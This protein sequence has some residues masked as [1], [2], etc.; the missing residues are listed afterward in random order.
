[1]GPPYRRRLLCVVFFSALAS[2]GLYFSPQALIASV[3][4]VGAVLNPPP[5]AGG[6]V[7]GGIT[8]GDGAYGS[9]TV[10]AGTAVTTSNTTNMGNALAGIGVLSLTGFGSDWT[11]TGATSDL[12]VGD[13]GVGSVTVDSSA[14][15]VVADDVF[16]GNLSTSSGS[17]TV[18][19]LGS[20]LDPGDDVLIG[21]AGVGHVDVTNGGGVD[22]DAIIVGDGSSGR[23]FVTITGDQS[24][25]T[26]GVVFV[27]DVG[28][29]RVDIASGGRLTTSGQLNLGNFA[30]SVGIVDVSGIGSLV[31]FPSAII[32]G[33]GTG[34]LLIRGGARVTSSGAITVGNSATAV[35]NLTVDGAGSRLSVVGNL[36]T[37][38]G[39]A[40]ITLSNGGVLSTTTSSLIN[41]LAR[42][43]LAGGRWEST[44]LASDAIVVAGLLEG[45]GTIDAQGVTINVGPPRGRLYTSASDHMLITGLVDN[46]GLVDLAGGELEI[47]GALNNSGDIDARHGAT[48]RVGNTGFDN[49][50]GAQLAITSGVVDVFG[51]VDNNAGAE[52]AVVGGATGIFH[53]AVTNSGT[54]FVSASSEIVLLGSLSFVPGSTIGVDLA[55]ITAT[56]PPTDAFGLLDII[57]ST[58]LSG[59]LSV[60][61]ASGF[62]PTLGESYQILRASGGLAGTFAS[63]SLPPLGG[64]MALKVVYDPT[65]V[66]LKIIQ[67]VSP[68]F[69]MDGDIDGVDADLLVMEIVAMTNGSLFDLTGDGSVTAADLSQW[70]VDAGAANLPSGNPYLV[71]DANLNGSVDG[72]DFIMWNSNKFT[73]NPRWTQ[74][75]FNADGFVDG[76]DFNLWNE[77]KFQSSAIDQSAVPEP[78]GGLLGLAMGIAVAFRSNPTR[79]GLARRPATTMVRCRPWQD[80]SCARETGPTAR[81]SP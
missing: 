53:D 67:A 10:T 47:L 51:V 62:I 11:I 33:S 76:S 57:G 40:S 14:R 66:M 39:E 74:G 31:S 68:D 24:R 22:S 35:G 4:S 18:T 59:A 38:N 25:W 19:D 54:I 48:L 16:V 70:L 75:D 9:V 56:S 65:S 77:N 5:V 78:V 32:G 20:V 55:P 61:L 44:H 15:L 21:V 36:S 49:N 52:I 71:G 80:A 73:V 23:G 43:T 42:L 12:A 69:D 58:T 45:S 41:A 17:V 64:G 46:S 28:S 8:I 7:A 81:Y 6:A 63:T 13:E 27:G 3:T 34:T 1:M 72:S 79:W 37:P 26:A 50:S 2:H 29:G 30:G 60:S